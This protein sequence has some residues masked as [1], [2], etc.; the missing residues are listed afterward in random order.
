MAKWG[1]IGGG[2]GRRGYYFENALNYACLY[3][4]GGEILSGVYRTAQPVATAVD[5][6][7][8]GFLDG[9]T[10]INVP[11]SRQ[12]CTAVREQYAAAVAAQAQPAEAQP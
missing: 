7:V 4:Q 11:N 2:R 3:L 8:Q 9:V 10:V 5:D 12:F 6:A 1:K